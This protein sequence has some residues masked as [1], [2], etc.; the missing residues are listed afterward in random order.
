MKKR[1]VSF[2][3]V[4]AMI[5]TNTAFL[6]LHVAAEENFVE[7]NTSNTLFDDVGDGNIE[8]GEMPSENNS[9][10]PD[11]R[12]DLGEQEVG[13][14]S[15]NETE[16]D[17]SEIG[18]PQDGNTIEYILENYMDYSELNNAQKLV[19]CEEYDV[20]DGGMTET[21]EL[22]YHLLE[23]VELIAFAKKY[24]LDLELASAFAMTAGGYSAAAIQVEALSGYKDD[25][26]LSDNTIEEFKS[27]IIEGFELDD[28]VYAYIVSQVIGEEL[29]NIISYEPEK[30]ETD[31]ETVQIIQAIFEQFCVKMSV[32]YAY[33]I[34]MD[35]TADQLLESIYEYQ[36]E[37][38]IYVASK[39]QGMVMMS[40]PAGEEPPAPSA[41]YY[42]KNYGAENVNLGDGSISYT[43]NIAILAGKNGLNL[44]LKLR[45]DSSKAAINTKGGSLVQPITY[46]PIGEVSDIN[47]RETEGHANTL[48]DTQNYYG[49]GWSMALPYLTTEIGGY[50]TYVSAEGATKTARGSYFYDEPGNSWSLP[51]QQKLKNVKFVSDSTIFYYDEENNPVYTGKSVQHSDGI[52][53]H[54]GYNG[55]II[56]KTD[57]FGNKILYKYITFEG[58][59]VISEI[60][61]TA[62]RVVIF[63]YLTENT[64]KTMRVILP[65]GSDVT[66]V[67][68]EIDGHA[69]EYTIT[70][71]IDQL[72]N[73]TQFEYNIQQGY[74]QY[75]YNNQSYSSHTMIYYA[76]LSKITY[77]TG[78]TSNYSYESVY[79]HTEYSN[80]AMKQFKIYERYDYDTGKTLNK[81]R[82]SY[83][84]DISQFE[85]QH[86]GWYD[87]DPTNYTTTESRIHQILT[88]DMTYEERSVSTKYV[89]TY[90]DNRLIEEISSDTIKL[91][92]YDIDYKL[93]SK[94]T[95]R[96]YGDSSRTGPYVEQVTETT[97]DQYGNAIEVL[98]PQATAK[99]S[100]EY[101]TTTDYIMSNN[102][103]SPY[104]LPLSREYKK[105]AQTTI[106]ESYILTNDKKNI[107]VAQTYEVKGGVSTL[108]AKKSYTYDAYGN[109][110]SENA[111]K[112]S[113]SYITTEYS[114]DDNNGNND[115]NQGIDFDGLYMTGQTTYGMVNADGQ[116]VNGGTVD[117]EIKYDIMGRAV[118]TTDGNGN[119]SEVE[120]DLL[121]RAVVLT[122]PDETEKT[123]TYFDTA[124]KLEA[125]NE[126]SET[127]T[128]QYDGLGNIIRIDGLPELQTYEY[129]IAGRISKKKV[130]GVTTVYLYDTRGRLE[131]VLSGEFGN[132]QKFSARFK[133]EETY[134][135]T[136]ENTQVWGPSSQT[137]WRTEPC[138]VT[139]KT[140]V[141]KDGTP[142]IVTKEYTD[143]LG[144]LVK[145]SRL[146]GSAEY[147]DTFE[148]DYLGNKIKE[149]TAIAHDEYS[150]IA[151][152]D[153]KSVV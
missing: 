148:Y 136:V 107:L 4:L 111:Y 135:Y 9:E 118:E 86:N 54:F 152:T 22:G 24:Q 141:S 81:V 139:T 103:Q 67:L 120:Y 140:I 123:N 113:N 131:R 74:T 134:A 57:R 31:Q 121:G 108:V 17:D 45:Y 90:A 100:N 62:G 129:D 72:G 132:A 40:A 37:K 34:E 5:F 36:Y 61:D 43:E 1:I 80:Y 125:T 97:Y 56:A 85:F 92:E 63:E 91:T 32:L 94:V 130:N 124:N 96:T 59:T 106:R 15:G 151:V 75:V 98:G 95:V 60:I 51:P 48:D 142:P 127:I 53:E 19:F 82:Y 104:Q 52:T 150:N 93:P 138:A 117:V 11:G 35:I 49:T 73:E 112:T 87:P 42:Y 133:Y 20:T 115:I 137:G 47:S 25:F 29:S 28:I 153:R 30:I 21:E 55:R 64:Q 99:L 128:Y 38:G 109:M 26:D 119:T 65:D 144:R 14:P 50:F 6:G 70:K 83:D 88:Y 143:N 41:P 8:N 44:D 46:L 76:N 89:F 12:E 78:M 13:N 84:Y 66:F 77:P 10:I 145:R 3:I 33:I 116:T 7:E 102:Q 71:K 79:R 69:N 122:N 147:I 110:T 27:L 149:K 2:V 23:A 146:N 18:E 68:E 126:N 39:M 101:K 58:M 114:Y 105:D 16:N